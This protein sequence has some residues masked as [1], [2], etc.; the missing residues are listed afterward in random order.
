M[1]STI[2]VHGAGSANTLSAASSERQRWVDLVLDFD[3]G[4]EEHRSAL[5]GVDVIRNIL[6]SVLRVIWVGSIN[7]KSLHFSLFLG[8]KSLVEFF[9][10]VNFEH[11]WHISDTNILISRRENSQLVSNGGVLHHSLTNDEISL[12]D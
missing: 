9:S 8:G 7:V 11:I 5:V 1:M 10:I 12:E 3:E 4:V 2:D 6:W